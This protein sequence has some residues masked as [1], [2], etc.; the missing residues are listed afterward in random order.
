MKIEEAIELIKTHNE[1]HQ[2]KEPFAVHITE[3]LEMAVSAL[4]K[5]IPKKPI[6]FKR[7]AHNFETGE[8]PYTHYKCEHITPYNYEY[9]YDDYKCPSCN[10]IIS[11]GNPNYY[12]HCGQALDWSD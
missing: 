3:A 12:C 6:V 11:E 8:C 4:E 2:R 7:T 10:K 9:Q 1:I 5:Q